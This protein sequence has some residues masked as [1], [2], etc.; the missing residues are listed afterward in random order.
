[1]SLCASSQ[2]HMAAGMNPV[3]AGGLLNLREQ[4]SVESLADDRA[5]S[6]L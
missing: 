4:A 5:Q 1:M 3:Y 6:A 2:V